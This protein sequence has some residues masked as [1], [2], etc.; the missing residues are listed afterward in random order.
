MSI[1]CAFISIKGLENAPKKDV[2]ES[3]KEHGEKSGKN[4]FSDRVK[5][6]TEQIV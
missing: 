1:F 4:L 2:K 5:I 3:R 6:G